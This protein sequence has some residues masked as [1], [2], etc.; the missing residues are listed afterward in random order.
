MMAERIVGL[1]E[2]GAALQEE[3]KDAAARRLARSRSL[4]A[5]RRHARRSLHLSHQLRGKYPQFVYWLAMPFFAP[6]P[7]EVD[8]FLHQPGMAEKNLTLDWYPVGT[9]PFMLTQNNPNSRMVL[10]RNPNFHGETYPCRASPATRRPG[11]WPT[12]ASPCR[13]STRRSSRARRR[14]FPTGTSS[15][16]AITMLPGFPRTASTRRCGSA[17]GGDVQPDRRDAREGDR[18]LTSVRASIFYMGFNMLDPVVGGLSEQA[19][20]LRQAL[21]IAIDQEEF[22]SIFMNGRG[23]AATSPLPPGIFGYLEGRR[24]S[25]R[26]STTG[27]TG[28]RG[29][30]RSRWRRNCSPKPAGRM[31]AMPDRRAAGAQPRYH[32]RRHGRQ[33]AARLADAA[34]RQARH[35][36]RRSLD[37]L[38]PL[39]GEGSQGRGAA[40]LP[41]LER[42]LSRIRRTSCSCSPAPRA[43]SPRAARTPRTTPIPSSTA[44][45]SR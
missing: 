14:A 18:L 8:R 41:R 30:S 10:E 11:C 23:I 4:S 26:W 9:G 35:P 43:R 37:R 21:S 44:S 36:A 33:V 27:S 3:A 39:P 34:V 20:K 29:A 22:I 31:V 12:A 7:R 24:A 17:V 13:S 28:G 40:L 32:Q 5:R 25:T 1:R 16:R 6:V 15:C 2:L 38:Q 42:R 45:S 19:T